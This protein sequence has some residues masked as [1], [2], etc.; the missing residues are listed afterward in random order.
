MVVVYIQNG[1]L[2][3]VQAKRRATAVN[4]CRHP[5]LSHSS[6]EE[7]SEEW[8]GSPPICQKSGKG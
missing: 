6:S 4:Y 3:S 2:P 8:T 1:N 5:A 7:R